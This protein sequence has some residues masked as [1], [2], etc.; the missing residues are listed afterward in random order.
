[1]LAHRPPIADL[2]ETLSQAMVTLDTRE[3][4]LALG[5]Y[6]KLAE[7]EPV[8]AAALAADLGHQE[9]EVAGALEGWPG[10]F[11]AEDGRVISF[12]GLAIPEMPHSF[13]VGGHQLFTWCAWDALFIPELIG[14]AAEV[15][16][17]SPASDEEVRLIVEPNA[18]RE[19]EPE[20]AVVSMLPP[21]EAFDYRV[22]TSFCHYVHFFPSSAE[23]EGWVA[24]HGGTFLLSVPEAHELGRL[25]NRK[26]FGAL[27]PSGSGQKG[28]P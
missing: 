7:G 2:A 9:A 27:L 11:R 26:Q 25:V 20:S 8:S 15:E 23:G 13:R 10:L 4:E 1:M 22:M 18:V 12:W 19:V 3:Q 17:R 14:Q 16:S 24:E 21:A 28:L 6:R 5:L